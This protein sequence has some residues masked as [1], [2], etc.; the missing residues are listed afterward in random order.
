M[1]LKLGAQGGSLLSNCIRLLIRH[2]GPC[3]ES[4]SVSALVHAW[5]SELAGFVV[6]V[7]DLLLILGTH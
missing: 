7:A 3:L 5:N 6:C 4:V 1:H 2:I